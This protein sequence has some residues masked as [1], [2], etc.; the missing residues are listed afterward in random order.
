MG[1]KDKTGT[2]KEFRAGKSAENYDFT[3]TSSFTSHNFEVM[4]KF[5]AWRSEHDF[6]R[7]RGV[8]KCIELA[9]KDFVV[10]STPSA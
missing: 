10:P 4:Q 5:D 1:I 7:S 8:E 3:Y 2:F 9:L 6:D